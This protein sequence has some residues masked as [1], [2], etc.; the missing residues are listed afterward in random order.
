MDNQEVSKITKNLEAGQI[1]P[2]S[3]SLSLK[4]MITMSELSIYGAG[5]AVFKSHVYSALGAKLFGG[6]NMIVWVDYQLEKDQEP[7]W[8]CEEGFQQ[9]LLGR[10]CQVPQLWKSTTSPGDYPL[11]CSVSA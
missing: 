5:E 6:E 4:D 1:H 2:T 10:R 3:G 7:P 11:P 8:N 9:D